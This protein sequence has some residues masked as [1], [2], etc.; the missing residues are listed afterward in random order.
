MATFAAVML[1]LGVA[2]GVV[3]QWL[4]KPAQWEVRS[5]GSIVLTEI[6]ARDQ[7]GVIVVFVVAGAVASLVWAF[8]STFALRDLGW[9]LTPFV[10]I[11]TLLAGVI[12]WQVGVALGPVGPKSAV[13]PSVGDMLPSKLAID[14]VAPLVV[15]PLFGVI[16]L[17]AAMWMTKEAD[18]YVDMQ[19]DA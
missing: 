17:L 10:I 12:A 11:V 7:F 2:S 16:G 19:Q 1:L 18:E 5:D 3:W 15:W 14:G 4:A 6:A 13:N 9:R 8:G